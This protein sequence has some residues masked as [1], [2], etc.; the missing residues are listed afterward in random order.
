MTQKKNN[1]LY[2]ILKLY[3]NYDVQLSIKNV[4]RRLKKACSYM[5]TDTNTALNVSTIIQIYL[6][7]E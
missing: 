2:E 5:R 3:T 1:Y 4:R 7:Q 6:D